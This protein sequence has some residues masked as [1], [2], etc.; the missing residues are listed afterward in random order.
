MRLFETFSASGLWEPNPDDPHNRD[1]AN[2]YWYR[3]ESVGVDWLNGQ[4]S[5]VVVRIPE[6]PIK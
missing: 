6:V 1:H 2:K 5:K 4:V 3:P